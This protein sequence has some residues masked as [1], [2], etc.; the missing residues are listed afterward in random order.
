MYFRVMGPTTMP[1]IYICEI[2]KIL[3]DIFIICGIVIVW[4]PKVSRL[5]LVVGLKA[6]SE[7]EQ[8]YMHDTD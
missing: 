7:L 2:A 8:M 6:K 5:L 3:E 4:R 1:H